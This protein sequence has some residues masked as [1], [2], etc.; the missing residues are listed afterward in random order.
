VEQEAFK[1]QP[2]EVSPLIGTPQGHVVVKC[3]RRIPPET[4]VTLE[5]VR[6]QLEPEVRKRK[7]DLEMGVAFKELWTKAHPQL[8]LRDPSRP[9]DVQTETSQALSDLPAEQRSRLH[10]P[11]PASPA[12]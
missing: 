6:P 10:L 9:V 2:G 1:L 7:V 11:V 8:L 12:H 5:Q 3:D 4:G